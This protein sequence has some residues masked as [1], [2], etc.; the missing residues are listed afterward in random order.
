MKFI[1]KILLKL[2]YSKHITVNEFKEHFDNVSHERY[3][4][5]HGVT[6][7]AVGRAK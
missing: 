2:N 6:E 7:R 4:E 5:E 1:R 3:V